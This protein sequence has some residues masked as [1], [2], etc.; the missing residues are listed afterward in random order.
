MREWVGRGEEGALC[1]LLKR[2]MYGFMHISEGQVMQPRLG[3]KES[4][5]KPSSFVLKEV[6]LGG[7]YGSVVHPMRTAGLSSARWRSHT[8]Q[9]STC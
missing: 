6:K 1:H 2:E 4:V 5:T 8:L 7:L 3:V 9:R